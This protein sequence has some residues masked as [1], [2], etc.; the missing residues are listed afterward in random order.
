MTAPPGDPRRP[1]GERKDKPLVSR[2][3]QARTAV[4]PAGRRRASMGLPASAPSK[5]AAKSGS[6]RKRSSFKQ[7]ALPLLG[8]LAVAVMSGLGAYMYSQPKKQVAAAAPLPP[9]SVSMSVPKMAEPLR[10]PAVMPHLET[11]EPVVR[12]PAAAEPPPWQRYA[13]AAPTKP[14]PRL[15]IVIDDLG[16]DAAA[17]RKIADLPPPLTMAFLPYA[18]DLPSQ[19]LNARL[20]GHELLVHLPMEPS[21]NNDPGRNALLTG[22]PQAELMERLKWNLSRFSGYV[23]VNNHMGSRFTADADAMA[24]VI[25]ELKARGLLFL[26]SRTTNATVG[27]QMATAAG[28]P[29]VARNIFLD[30]E[31]EVSAIRQQLLAA[32]NVARKSGAAVAIG[33]PYKE[34]LAA[35]KAYIPEAKARGIV[36]APVSAL[37]KAPLTSLAENR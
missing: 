21:H 4:I 23:G 33:H 14:G 3:A 28:V 34:T 25:S 8:L 30:N 36:F 12:R 11:V 27:D 5:P 32:E 17:T 6:R 16:L 31:K 1:L 37:A 2:K 15:A 10:K 22:L 18:R 20:K 19:T 9:P 26:D 7:T 24:P 29:H 13:A 35:L